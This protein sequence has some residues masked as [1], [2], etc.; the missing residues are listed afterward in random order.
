MYVCVSVSSCTPVPR[1][2]AGWLYGE[3]DGESGSFPSEYVVP[4]ASQGIDQP[5]EAAVEVSRHAALL[6]LKLV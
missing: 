2:L 4:I 6:W 5:S 3:L 1:C